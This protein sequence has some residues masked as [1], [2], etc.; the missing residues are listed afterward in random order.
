V[1]RH[2][3]MRHLEQL[4]LAAPVAAR[5]LVVTDSLFSMDGDYADLKV[6]RSFGQGGGCWKAAVRHGADAKSAPPRPLK[7]FIK[8][9][10]GSCVGGLRVP[11]SGAVA[12][13]V[14]VCV[15]GGGV[16]ARHWGRVLSVRP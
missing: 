10:P 5:K 8:Q 4:L 13:C 1:Y 12:G 14:F 15:W 7:L 2:N 11:T 3:D 9:H 16:V 6:C